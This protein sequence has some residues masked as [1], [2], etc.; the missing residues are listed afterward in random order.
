MT[1][2]RRIRLGQE[3]SPN[4]WRRGQSTAGAGT[5]EKDVSAPV[6]LE[7]H[8]RPKKSQPRAAAASQ[9]R[10]LPHRPAPTKPTLLASLGTQCPQHQPRPLAARKKVNHGPCLRSSG[11]PPTGSRVH[12]TRGDLWVGRPSRVGA[13]P[14]GDRPELRME[15]LVQGHPW[16]P[17]LDRGRSIAVRIRMHA[18]PKNQCPHYSIT[19]NRNLK[20]ISK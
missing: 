17:E 7:A 9:A 12:D 6:A 1:T 13:I 15:C 3:S 8:V 11:R 16:K 14:V 5:Q 2:S 19:A 4:P 10:R 18:G 20:T